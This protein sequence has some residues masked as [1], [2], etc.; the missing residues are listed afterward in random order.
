MNLIDLGRQ[1]GD[2]DLLR[3]LVEA[4]LA[5]LIEFEVAELIGASCGAVAGGFDNCFQAVAPT[6][7]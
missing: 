1:C 5:K 2:Q 6:S 4:A 7:I 3:R